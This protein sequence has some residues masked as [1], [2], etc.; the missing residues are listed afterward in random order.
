MIARFEHR[1]DRPIRLTTTPSC[2]AAGF[3]VRH[4]ATVL[5]VVRDA[6]EQSVEMVTSILFWAGSFVRLQRYS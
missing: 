1:N 6:D 2:H 3:R 4:A 5:L